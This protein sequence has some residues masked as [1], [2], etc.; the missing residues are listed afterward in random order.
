MHSCQSCGPA[1]PRFPA[2]AAACGK[3]LFLLPTGTGN[4]EQE[5]A[6]EAALQQ[7]LAASGSSGSGSI[8]EGQLVSWQRW[9]GGSS[10]SGDSSE[11]VV[12]LHRFQLKY[13]TW[14]GRGDYFATVAPTGNTQ[15]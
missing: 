15:V 8:E 4:E 3:R 9:Q 2:P 14:H 13:V 5:A 10:G 12:V 7:A 11:G 6:T 1:P